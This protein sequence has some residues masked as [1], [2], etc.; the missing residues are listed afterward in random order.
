VLAQPVFQHR[1]LEPIGVIMT[2]TIAEILE[3]WHAP[4]RLPSSQNSES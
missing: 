4:A 1:R 2:E 3:G